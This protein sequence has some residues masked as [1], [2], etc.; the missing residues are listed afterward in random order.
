[1]KKIIFTSP[2]NNYPPAGGPELRIFN[3]LVSL[4]AIA[5]V[6][7]LFQTPPESIKNI[8]RLATEY[9]NLHLN[10]KFLFPYN[11]PQAIRKKIT[12]FV[13]IYF[14]GIWPKIVLFIQ[15]KQIL[16][17]AKR[18]NINI[19]WF[20]YG[21]I[22]YELIRGVRKLNSEIKII[23]DTDSVWSRFILRK[24]KYVKDSK[25]ISSI[26]KQGCE[27]KLEEKKIVLL[28]DII[29]AVSVVDKKY[30]EKISPNKNKIM[31]F[32]NVVNQ[33]DYERVSKISDSLHGIYIYLS[34]TF[35]F[36]SS[37]EDAAIWFIT[38]VLPIVKKHIPDI[39]LL[40][41]GRSADTVLSRY[42][43]LKNVYIKGYV[44]STIPYLK[45]AKVSVVPLRWESGTRFKI[46]EA[47][48]CHIPVVS[49]SLGAEGLE[50]T[51]GE[52]IKIADSPVKFA[53]S[54]IETINNPIKSKAQSK[55][56]YKLIQKKY[57]I[58]SLSNQ[59]KAVLESLNR[60]TK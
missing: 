50:V 53:H 25:V 26:R 40:I 37:M 22:S 8:K 17:Y 59:G 24:S 30:Y 21:N 45:G 41:V 15:A 19:I 38:K 27:K 55:K 12:N 29:T 49:T 32:S 33:K 51:N 11:L 42:Q 13:A 57:S 36:N 2:I 48:I 60:E 43:G 52:N 31:I 10:K 1:M 58:N 4:S 35:G 34:G 3:S 20:G 18:N 39:K 7:V 56:L 54:I 28:S 47:G 14:P 16:R 23:C 46:L 9:K 5:E 44:K 6:H